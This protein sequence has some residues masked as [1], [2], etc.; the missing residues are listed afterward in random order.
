MG[1]KALEDGIH[2]M[3]ATPHTLNG[4]YFNG[5]SKIKSETSSLQKSLLEL[6]ID[7]RL[8]PG[9]EVY[10]CP[11]V[12]EQIDAGDALTVDDA[13]RYILIELPTHIVPSGVKEEVF[14]LRLRGITPIISHPERNL[15]IQKDTGVLRELILMG[16]I[17]QVTAMSI[18]G[19]FGEAAKVCSEKLLTNRLV[20]VISS[21]GHSDG[22][23]API[24]S[25]GVEAAAEILGNQEEAEMMVKNIPYAILSG[26]L[27]EIPEPAGAKI[28]HHE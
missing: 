4:V 25:R 26:D 12:M 14:S 15:A 9:A 21:D 22:R 18:T 8:Y 1:R 27:L 7:L 24:L 10:L 6:G 5:A 28:R 20:H 16:A 13:K 23:R 17:G 11:H 19:D 3:V 2:T